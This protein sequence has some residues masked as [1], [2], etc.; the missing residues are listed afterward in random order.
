MIP[1][2]RGE[3][4]KLLKRRESK[5]HGR[6]EKKRESGRKTGQ[7]SERKRNGLQRE[8]YRRTGS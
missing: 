1:R 5:L 3:S 6:D 8:E 2:K 4:E 7:A